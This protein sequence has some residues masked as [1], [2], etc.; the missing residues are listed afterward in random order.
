MRRTRRVYANILW[1]N[2]GIGHEPSRSRKYIR[3]PRRH[4][5]HSAPPLALF[6]M[7]WQISMLIII[8]SQAKSRRRKWH[9]EPINKN[10]EY[11]KSSIKNQPQHRLTSKTLKRWKR[12][13]EERKWLGISLGLAVRCCATKENF[14]R[15][16]RH[17]WVSYI[18]LEW[19]YL[20]S[21]RCTISI[22][23]VDRNK[24]WWM[25]RFS[26]KITVEHFNWY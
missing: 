5:R 2:K 25:F 15:W 24:F 4:S 17:F 16:K 18:K 3:A 10:K 20:F 22:K 7:I 12:N 14:F 6:W 9:T 21:G 1:D 19:N 23:S 8:I 26:P 11:N 13:E